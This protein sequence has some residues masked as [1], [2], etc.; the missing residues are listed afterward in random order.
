[1]SKAQRLSPGPAA[2]LETLE[3]AAEA[4]VAL[5]RFQWRHETA[6][7]APP[8]VRFLF[9]P[10]KLVAKG[11]VVMRDGGHFALTDAGRA[12][13]AAHRAAVAQAPSP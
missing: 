4:D 6:R 3:R 2:A 1:M 12:A 11:F 13:L 8:G 5:G 9:Q 10:D 7:R